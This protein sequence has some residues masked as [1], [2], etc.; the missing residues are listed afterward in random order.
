L[1]FGARRCFSHCHCPLPKYFAGGGVQAITATTSSSRRFHSQDMSGPRGSTRPISVGRLANPSNGLSTVDLASS[2]T[3]AVFRASKKAD[4][5]EGGRSVAEAEAEVEVYLAVDVADPSRANDEVDDAAAVV[6]LAR[7]AAK[8]AARV[9]ATG[10]DGLK[11]AEK[12]AAETAGRRGTELVG[13]LGAWE[14]REWRV[15]GDRFRV[16]FRN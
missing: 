16:G 13:G 14:W 6:L 15:W 1:V 7:V 2:F 9:V 12:V 11:R 8:A 5:T 4:S 10:T 3:A